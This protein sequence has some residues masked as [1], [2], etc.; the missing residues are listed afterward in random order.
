MLTLFIAVAAAGLSQWTH[1]EC[2][3]SAL[4][5]V[6]GVSTA[7]D[8]H[9]AVTRIAVARI[10]RSTSRTTR[11][12][13][14]GARTSSAFADMPTLRRVMAMGMGQRLVGDQ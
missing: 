11:R 9:L 8:G 4:G 13:S 14:N 3:P 1:W 2:P 6:G 5:I 12:P 10:A 7:E